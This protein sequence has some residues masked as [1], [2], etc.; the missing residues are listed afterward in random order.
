MG[1]AP[2]P[3]ITF[4]CGTHGR[5]SVPALYDGE[6]RMRHAGAGDHDWCF[7]ARFTERQVREVDRETA[8]A[9]LTREDGES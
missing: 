3:G 5:L 9:A 7:S 8:L 6:A 1:R 2:Q 4:I